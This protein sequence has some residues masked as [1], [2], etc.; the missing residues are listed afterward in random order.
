MGNRR[1]KKQNNDD[2][3]EADFDESAM[4][5]IPGSD[6]A[7]ERAERTER[8]ID[9][10]LSQVGSS[11]EVRILRVNS[12][13]GN[14][15]LAG[16]V[17][18]EDFSLDLLMEHYG[19]GSYI[20]KV[21]D[22]KELVGKVS[23]EVDSSIPAKNPRMRQAA[24]PA[25]QNPNDV[26]T[27]MIAGQAESNRRTMEMM[28]AMMAGV[29]TMMTSMMTAAKT[30]QQPSVDPLAMLEKA[31]TIMRPATPTKS[32]I[33]EL[34][35]LM[36][37]REMLVPEAATDD[38]TMGVVS[39]AIDTIGKIAD[40][41]PVPQQ[42]RVPPRAT[43][44]PASLPPQAEVAEPMTSNRVWIQESLPHMP[45][46]RLQLG[47]LSPEKAAGV[48]AALLSDEAFSDLYLDISDGVSVG[49]D[50][51][52]QTLM[53]FAERTVKQLQL[54]VEHTA[55]LAQT[56]LELVVIYND[57]FGEDD[58]S[59][60]SA[61]SVSSSSPATQ[62]EGSGGSTDGVGSNGIE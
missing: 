53:P 20:L 6:E 11:A 14:P 55:W 4:P 39:K 48:I 25:Q 18:A 34:K 12:D 42:R 40:R 50:V 31:A 9:D 22:G 45:M 41:Q 17:K 36:E 3:N 28:T 2:I 27:A 49:T 61:E 47:V 59:E 1:G 51:S 21:Y 26:L 56:A 30:T 19:G 37:L 13:T 15:A 38:G 35:E 32:A 58:E 8:D 29:T 62:E 33:G 44:T 5:K 60:Q 54:P 7:V 23:Y 16:K 57:E 52:A 24:A 46:L 43:A 10:V